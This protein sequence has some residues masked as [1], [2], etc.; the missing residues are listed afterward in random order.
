MQ[1]STADRWAR[2]RERRQ[3]VA[4]NR[5][6]D[7]LDRPAG[8]ALRKRCGA[9]V[10]IRLLV[11]ADEAFHI[12]IEQGHFVGEFRA[13]AAIG[14]FDPQAVN[15]V[16]TKIGDPDRLYRLAR[17]RHR[18][19]LAARSVRAVPSRVPPHNSPAEPAALCLL[20]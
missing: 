1:R 2:R 10:K 11:E 17:A 7:Q 16:Q 12:G 19:F 8:I 4:C 14:F 13:P 3:S 20:Q 18:G 15:G 9:A 5:E 6:V